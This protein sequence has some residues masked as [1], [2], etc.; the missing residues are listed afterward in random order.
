MKLVIAAGCPYTD[1][2]MVVPTLMGAGLKPADDAISVWQDQLLA[3]AGVEEWLQLRQP[4]Q[5]DTSMEERLALLLSGNQSYTDNLVVNRC[6]WL[7][8]FWATRYP[9]T[10]FLLFFTCAE[11]ALA[12][13]LMC[14]IE[15]VKFV[16]EWKANTHHLIRFQRRYRQRAL[17]LSAEAA[18]RY[19]DALIEAT[20][21]IGLSMQVATE[22]VNRETPEIPG[23]ERFLAHRLVA[24]DPSISALQMELDA[25]AQPLGDLPAQTSNVALDKLL[26]CYLLTRQDHQQLRAQLRHEQNE[27]ERV[28]LQKE[29]LEQ[30]KKAKGLELQQLQ[31][32]MVQVEQ[33]REKLEATN[34]SLQA[35]KKEA[36]EENQQLIRQLHDTQEEFEKAFLA[37]QQLEQAEKAKGLELQQLQTRMVQVEQTRE[38]LE[39]TNQSLQAGK[40]KAL[41]ENQLLIRQ[42]HD[43]QEEFEKALVAKQQLEQAEKAKGLELQQL[44]ARMIQVEQTR[45]KLKETNQSLEANRKE[46]LEENE[47][48]LKQLHQVQE[49]LEHYFLKYQETL[50]RQAPVPEVQALTLEGIPE[51]EE[52]RQPIPQSRKTPAWTR[53]RL[54]RA[55]VKPFKRTD[56]KKE[57]IR[58]QA[59]VLNQSGLFDQQWYLS[60]YPDVAAAGVDPT[61]HYLQIGA[62]EGRNPSSKFDTVYYLQSNP[63]VAAA[64][65]NPL[66]HYIQFGISE[67]RQTC[68]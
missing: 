15:P 4:L 17:L 52:G 43:T 64:G 63:D 66:L 67:G 41:E 10:R 60:K 26:K 61:E 16:E 13:A 25:R 8:D 3:A 40:K 45:E 62:T 36:L 48:L 28:R 1:W 57:K 58:R 51:I 6:P 56:R 59:E 47:L 37:K 23:M 12:Q 32:R 35:G 29:Q 31:T 42:L 11:T 19:P 68:G 24:N 20:R 22:S 49:E 14:G 34:Q 65:V 39:A 38:K 7:L 44:Q 9:D 33:T 30:A 27:L 46:A 53:H 5:P 54:I 18:N 21:H 50:N 55:L 2:E